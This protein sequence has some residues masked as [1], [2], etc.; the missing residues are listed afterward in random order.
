M[1]WKRSDRG[2]PR[3]QTPRGALGPYLVGACASMA[4]L[5]VALAGCAGELPIPGQTSSTAATASTTTTEAPT[6]QLSDQIAA[7]WSEAIQKL[8]TLL[9]GTPPIATLQS[10]VAQLKEE[11]VQ[12]M[13]AFGRQAQELDEGQRQAAYERATDLLAGT[14]NTEWFRSYVRLYDEYAAG[15][16]QTSQD[17]A[18]LL[19]TFN[20]LTEYA[21]FDLLKEQ[22]PDEAAR[23][24]I[25]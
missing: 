16:D 3:G 25:P 8:V 17:F 1:G 2:R 18:I 9:E 19:S 22:N 13:V 14:A 5:A 20:T 6:T 4:M 24:G 15:A 7:T 12:K 21:F 10:P 23:L 11:Y